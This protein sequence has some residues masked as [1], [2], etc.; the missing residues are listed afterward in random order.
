MMDVQS[1][2]TI[3]ITLSHAHNYDD[4]YYLG[5]IFQSSLFKR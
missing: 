4:N 5:E 1:V 2:G 3:I